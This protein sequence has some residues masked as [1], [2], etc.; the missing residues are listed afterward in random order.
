MCTV[1][2]WEGFTQS[3]LSQVTQAPTLSDSTHMSYAERSL[4]RNG[5]KNGS[6]QGK[7]S[8]SCLMTTEFQFCKMKRPRDWLHGNVNI[9]NTEHLGMVRMAE[10]AMLFS[11]Q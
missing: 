10:S 4:L 5:S 11:P 7:K 8:R 2:H 9:L 3:R 6:C 1:S